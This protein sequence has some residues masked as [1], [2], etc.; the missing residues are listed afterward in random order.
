MSA[1]KT[2]SNELRIQLIQNVYDCALNAT[3]S[4]HNTVGGDLAYLMGAIAHG[5]HVELTARSGLVKML[6]K[7]FGPDFIVWDYIKIVDRR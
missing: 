6:V 4:F 3:E 2:R 7:E 5:K 1:I